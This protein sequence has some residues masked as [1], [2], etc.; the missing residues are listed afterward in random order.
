MRILPLTR[1]ISKS[2]FSNLKNLLISFIV[3]KPNILDNLLDCR[4]PPSGSTLFLDLI[5]F[6]IILADV[7][8]EKLKIRMMNELVNDLIHLSMNCVVEFVEFLWLYLG[9]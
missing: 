4:F 3:L 2:I 5:R 1:V 9:T 6:T 7:S 8:Q